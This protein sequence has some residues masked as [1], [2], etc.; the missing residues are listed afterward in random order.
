MKVLI[1]TNQFP[2]RNFPY[3]GVFIYSQTKEIQK[4]VKEVVVLAP[5]YANE[6]KFTIYDGIKLYRFHTF[7]KSTTDPLLRELFSGFSGLLSLFLFVISQILSIIKIVKKENIDIIHA[8][9]ILPSGFSSYLISHIMK[10]KLV[11]TTLGSDLTFCGKN[12]I[13]KKFLQFILVRISLLICITSELQKLANKICGKRITSRTIHIGIPRDVL[14]RNN[15]NK[16]NII[17]KEKSKYKLIFVGS[18]YYIKGIKHLLD[19][20]LI[21]SSRR[22]D[23][24]LDIIGGGDKTIEYKKYIKENNLEK[25]V[26]IHG[27]KNNDDV[28]KLIRK[29][30]IAIQASISEGLSVFLQESISL[31]KAVVATNVGGTSDIVIDGFNGFLIEPEN[32]QE[33]ADKIDILLSNPKK[34]QSYSK[35]SVKIRKEKLLLEEN[36]K[37]IVDIYYSI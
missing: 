34:L 33:L 15:L 3:K 11:I 22:Q 29:A 23:F 20:M 1:V 36:M 26:T 18:L 19:S 25:F 30:D 9:W 6:E 12:K 17:I 14:K 7:T 13:L 28:I 10:K 21:L 37:K 31:G 2:S 16:R 24:H 8:Y 4:L 5:N 32:P 27:F 35:N